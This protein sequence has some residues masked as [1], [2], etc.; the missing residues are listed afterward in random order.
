MEFKQTK[1]DLGGEL[2]VVK[3]DR[4]SEASA[5]VA[6]IRR[7][8]NKVRPVEGAGSDEFGFA[9]VFLASSPPLLLAQDQEELLASTERATSIDRA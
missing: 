7:P 4:G 1:M 9:D 5:E 3:R 2:V 6:T 8:E